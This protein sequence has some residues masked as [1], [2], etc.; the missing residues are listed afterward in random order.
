MIHARSTDKMKASEA[1]FFAHGFDKLPCDDLSCLFPEWNRMSIAWPE[2]VMRPLVIRMGPVLKCLSDDA[3][4]EFC[5]ANRD[6]HIERTAAGD[7]VVMV[8]SGGSSSSRNLRL[9]SRLLQWTEQDNRGVAFES[10]AGFTLPNGAVS[11]PDASWVLRERW[12]AIARQEQE[13]FPHLAPD[14][15]VELRSPSD[16][17][18]DL[19]AKMLEYRDQGVRLGWL[20]DPFARTVEIFRPGQEP[21]ILEAPAAVSGDPELPGFVL[22]TESLWA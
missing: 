9:A 18:H 6:L 22:P 14:F 4:L 1:L 10:S 15:V 12:D 20:I 5:R 2:V 7:V 19:R 17:I 16:S 3:F 11:S 13:R 8:P 21:Q